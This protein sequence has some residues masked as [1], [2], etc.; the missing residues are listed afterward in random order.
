MYIIQGRNLFF[1]PQEHDF[2]SQDFLNHLTFILHVEYVIFITR[3]IISMGHFCYTISSLSFFFPVF[4]CSFV[5]FVV[6][7]HIWSPSWWLPWIH[8][9]A[10]SVWM[11]WN[12]LTMNVRITLHNIPLFLQVVFT[13]CCVSHFT[14][15]FLPFC[16]PAHS[17]RFPH[18]CL[19]FFL[20]PFSLLRFSFFSFPILFCFP[21]FFPL[22]IFFLWRYYILNHDG[23]FLGAV[24]PAPA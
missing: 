7:W 4:T 21:L 23:H 8:M 9:N 20:S 3:F 18:L 1:L 24:L 10:P 2:K 5:F 13:L 22:F 14:L 15:V 12:F 19:F 11:R 17:S 6:Y 16:P